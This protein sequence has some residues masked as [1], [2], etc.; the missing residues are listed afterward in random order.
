[1]SA[2]RGSSLIEWRALHRPVGHNRV[3]LQRPILT[4]TSAPCDELPCRG[5]TLPSMG[6]LVNGPQLGAGRAW[7]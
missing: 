6:M 1:M 3:A 7:R 2:I 5:F 4:V